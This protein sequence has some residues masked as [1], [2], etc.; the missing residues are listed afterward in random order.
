MQRSRIKRNKKREMQT[1]V[2]VLMFWKESEIGIF[3]SNVAQ[4]QV[5]N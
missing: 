5:L 1:V 2:F 3:L 4:K